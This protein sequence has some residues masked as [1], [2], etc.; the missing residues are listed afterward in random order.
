MVARKFR[1]K[2]RFFIIIGVLAAMVVLL[3]LLLSKEKQTARIQMGT[4][5]YENTL[6]AV[7]VRDE[8]V[9]TSETWGKVTYL[10]SEGERVSKGAKIAVVYKSGYNDKLLQDLTNIQQEINDYIEQNVFQSVVPPQIEQINAKILDASQRIS[11]SVRGESDEDL[12]V[13]EQIMIDLLEQRMT[14]MRQEVKDPDDAYKKKLS[15]EQSLIERLEAWRSDIYAEQAGMVSFFFDGCENFLKPDSIHLL[16]KNDI[17]NLLTGRSIHDKTDTGT[18]EP[19]YRLVNNYKW[20]CLYYVDGNDS[21]ELTVD[22]K[23]NVTFDG[24]YERPYEGKIISANNVETGTLFVMEMTEDIGPMLSV[25][26]ANAVFTKQYEGAIVPNEALQKDEHGTVGIK[27]MKNQEEETFVAVTVVYSNDQ[28]A[29]VEP[30]DA[31]TPLEAGMT[32]V[33]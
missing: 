32:V 10:A 3:V 6:E 18:G 19:L 17:D 28:G 30:V 5:T 9:Y 14:R 16:T 4:L 21:L 33:L 25:R 13:L 26:Q 2:L 11:K 15:E 1:L 7:L 24:F 8:D 27:L 20:Y 12:L 23:Y 31:Q 22:E 29:I